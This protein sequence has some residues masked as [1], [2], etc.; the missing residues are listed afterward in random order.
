MPHSSVARLRQ[1]SALR[2]KYNGRLLDTPFARACAVCQ[3]AGSLSG[4]G[5]L[6]RH[7]AGSELSSMTDGRPLVPG[8]QLGSLRDPCDSLRGGDVGL[9]FEMRT[10]K[11][12]SGSTRWVPIFGDRCSRGFFFYQGQGSADPKTPR[13]YQ[14]DRKAWPLEGGSPSTADANQA[15]QM[16]NQ[17]PMRVVG[18]RVMASALPPFP[19]L[20]ILS[21]SGL[22]RRSLMVRFRLFSARSGIDISTSLRCRGEIATLDHACS[23]VASNPE[24]WTSHTLS[25]AAE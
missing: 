24:T 17:T 16:L 19:R 5:R 9:L 25:A 15:L 10:S 23:E 21:S 22:Q 12:C 7:P 8:P 14:D 2:S 18:E 20:R 1:N 4:A 3:S 11:A 13:A 6:G